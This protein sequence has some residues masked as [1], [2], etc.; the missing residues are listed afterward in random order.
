[1]AAIVGSETQIT[2]TLGQGSGVGCDQSSTGISGRRRRAAS[3]AAESRARSRTQR[4]PAASNDEA[5]D[6]PRRPGPMTAT[7][8]WL[9]VPMLQYGGSRTTRTSLEGCRDGSRI[10]LP[11][12]AVGEASWT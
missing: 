11:K 9:T 4:H 10:G 6:N 8:A 7:A 2:I 12:H 5:R 1:M 3:A